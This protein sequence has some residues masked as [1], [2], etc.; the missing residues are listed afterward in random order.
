MDSTSESVGIWKHW[1]TV[2]GVLTFFFVVSVGA[3]IAL[4]YS[5]HNSTAAETLNQIIANQPP[6]PK[7]EVDKTN[8]LDSLAAAHTAA[9]AQQAPAKAKSTASTSVSTT[10]TSASSSASIIDAKIKLL[11]ALRKTK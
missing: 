7:T 11:D 5:L 2:I 3:D 1:K 10:K 4:W 9:M 8:L 6:A